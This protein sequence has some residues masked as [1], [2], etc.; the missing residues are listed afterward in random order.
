MSAQIPFVKMQAVGND[1]VLLDA[2]QTGERHFPALAVAM[3]D[4]HFGVGADGLLVVSESDV[5]DLRFRMFNPDGTED[6]CGNGMRCAVKYWLDSRFAVADFPSPIAGA[7]WLQ[8]EHRSGIALATVEREKSVMGRV[9]VSMGVPSFDPKAIPLD[10]DTEMVEAPL[11][12][13]KEQF[14]VTSISIGTAHTVIFIEQSPLALPVPEAS[15]AIETHPLFPERTSVLWT[16]VC[17]RSHLEIG[18]WERAVGE[19]LGCGT[20]ACAAAVVAARLGLAD[21]KVTVASKGGE[22]EVSWLDSGEV[23]LAGEAK[24]VFRGG[25]NS[26]SN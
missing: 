21:R 7:P 12:V 20:G 25:W 8:V 11:S 1:F 5:A 18:I 22:S 17:D 24:E 13:G 10:T 3:C 19:T 2:R 26:T 6:T 14:R 15:V 9:T 23:L 16:Y 4:R